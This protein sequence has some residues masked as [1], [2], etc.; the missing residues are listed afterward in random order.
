[1]LTSNSKTNDYAESM[2][3]IIKQCI[4]E[5]VAKL[6]TISTAIVQSVNTNGTVNVYLPSK[7]DTIYSNISNHTPFL[8]NP[9]DGVELLVKNG[10]YSNCW[11]IAK[12]GETFE[13]SLQDMGV[14][15][16]EAKQGK[17][18]LDKME[19]LGLLLNVVNAEVTGM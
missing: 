9:G 17:E 13:G 6:S 19:D 7:E 14:N 11:I 3:S 4:S 15:K 2:L 8:L 16:L 12:H 1:M 5:E 10:S 18:L